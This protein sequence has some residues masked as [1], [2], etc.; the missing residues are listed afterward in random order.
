MGARPPRGDRRS[1]GG[2]ALFAD[3]GGHSM[4]RLRR[5]ETRG[6]ILTRVVEHDKR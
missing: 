1:H 4:T 2:S 3:D 6:A 5:L